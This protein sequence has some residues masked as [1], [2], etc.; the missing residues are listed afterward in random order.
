MKKQSKI[1][2]GTEVQWKWMGRFIEGFV[3]E[4]HLEPITKTIK[5]KAIKRNGSAANPAFFV[6]SLAGNVALKLQSEVQLRPKER[7]KSAKPK[8]FG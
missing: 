6:E 5:G 8:M 7:A 2:V 4:V 1:V 3:K